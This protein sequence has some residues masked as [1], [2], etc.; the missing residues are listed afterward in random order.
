[1]FEDHVI[2]GIWV[3]TVIGGMLGLL[4]IY[5]GNKG[6]KDSQDHMGLW[7]IYRDSVKQHFIYLLYPISF[8]GFDKVP[9]KTVDFRLMD[10]SALEDSS[11][12]KNFRPPQKFHRK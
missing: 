2:K 9:T 8:L 11:F 6:K 10:E 1:M 3:I 4:G 12:F 5:D 7:Q